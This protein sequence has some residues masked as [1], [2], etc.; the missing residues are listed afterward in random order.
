MVKELRKMGRLCWHS[1]RTEGASGAGKLKPRSSWPGDRHQ[2]ILE[3]RRLTAHE[4]SRRALTT[5][6]IAY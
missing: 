4:E 2:K 5:N 6:L 1:D 3:V